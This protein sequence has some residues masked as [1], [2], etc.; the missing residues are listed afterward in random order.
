MVANCGLVLVWRQFTV[1][2]I[3]HQAR[4]N[5]PSSQIPGEVP[6]EPRV[7]IL[8]K[9][10]FLTREEVCR[11]DLQQLIVSD[12]VPKV[13]ERPEAMGMV[14]AGHAI[15][16]VAHPRSPY[17]NVLLATSRCWCITYANAA[18]QQIQC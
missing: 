4:E 7:K 14:G 9:V 3:N 6:A 12:H 17:I 8:D 13:F 1:E 11:D 5:R 16:H 18:L 15:S 2:E 10:A